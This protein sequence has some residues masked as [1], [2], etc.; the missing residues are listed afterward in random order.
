MERS[1]DE[2][3]NDHR[4][5]AV[6]AGLAAGVIGPHRDGAIPP[7]G[8]LVAVRDPLPQARRTALSFGITGSANRFR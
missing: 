4:D 2:I 7:F 5:L 1:V 6:G 8:P 3:H